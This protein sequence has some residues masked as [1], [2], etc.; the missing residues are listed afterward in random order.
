MDYS[1]F[2]AV[3]GVQMKVSKVPTEFCPHIYDSLDMKDDIG[4]EVRISATVTMHSE[5][6]INRELNPLIS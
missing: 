4:L 2:E 1:I 6:L 5:K 3:L